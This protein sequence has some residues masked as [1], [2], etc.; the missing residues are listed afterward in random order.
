[1]QDTNEEYQCNTSSLYSL[2]KS[3]SRIC[4]YYIADNLFAHEILQKKNVN[5]VHVTYLDFKTALL[6]VLNARLKQKTSK[7]LLHV[8]TNHKT[9]KC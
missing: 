9:W 2:N 8:I 1:M 4:L 3:T 6:P 5:A 7:R